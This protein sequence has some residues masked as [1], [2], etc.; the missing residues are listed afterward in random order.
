M[1][2]GEEGGGNWGAFTQDINIKS[3]A[4]VLQSLLFLTISQ[5][6]EIY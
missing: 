5:G 6:K 4:D 1:E 2:E 3:C